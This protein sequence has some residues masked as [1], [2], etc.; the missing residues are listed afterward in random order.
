MAMSSIASFISLFIIVISERLFPFLAGF[1]DMSGMSFGVV[2][3]DLYCSVTMLV[4]LFGSSSYLLHTFK[5]P[6]LLV[7]FLYLFAYL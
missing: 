3:T 4:I 6:N 1:N 2:R 7:Y 5:G